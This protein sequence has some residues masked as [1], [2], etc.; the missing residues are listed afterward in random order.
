VRPDS[1]SRQRP[2][3]SSARSL[4]CPPRR[5]PSRFRGVTRG[6]L[7]HVVS[8]WPSGSASNQW[9][10]FEPPIPVVFDHAWFGR[11]S[12]HEPRLPIPAGPYNQS[13]TLDVQNKNLAL[14]PLQVDMAAFDATGRQVV[15]MQLT[16]PIK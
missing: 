12:T 11:S 4:R 1:S 10:P 2:L 15:C 6:S 8:T 13:L 3:Q 9:L 5:G 7:E 16:I 14:Q